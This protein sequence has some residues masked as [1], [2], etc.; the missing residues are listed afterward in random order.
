MGYIVPE[1]FRWPGFLSPSA[2]LKFAEVP[3]GLA[4]LSKVPV[5]GWTQI[6]LFCGFME[7]ANAKQDPKNPPGMLTGYEGTFGGPGVEFGRLG[8]FRGDRISD[9]KQKQRALNA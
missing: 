8:I 4:A 3:N 6:F 1:Y 5:V 9:P 7:L 2:N